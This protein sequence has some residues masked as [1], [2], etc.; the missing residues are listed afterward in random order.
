VS[1]EKKIRCTVQGGIRCNSRA[2][3]TTGAAKAANR[4]WTGLTAAERYM[5]L[6]AKEIKM[7]IAI[8]LFGVGVFFLVGCSKDDFGQYYELTFTDSTSTIV[9]GDSVHILLTQV[10]SSLRVKAHVP[11]EIRE[12]S[13]LRDTIRLHLDVL[14]GSYSPTPSPHKEIIIRNDTLFL[15]YAHMQPLGGFPKR[16]GYSSIAQIETSPVP[17]YYSVQKVI[18]R[19]SLHKYVTF[20]STLYR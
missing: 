8:L 17:V 11:Y 14:F 19:K 20:E 13:T 2:Y 18:I 3:E 6:L 7:K 1:H 12:D 9:F 15:W 16:S 4:L 10:P 5:K